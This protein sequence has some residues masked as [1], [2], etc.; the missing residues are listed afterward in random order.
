MSKHHI[1]KS[2]SEA[3]SIL[4]GK[5]RKVISGIRATTLEWYEEDK[6]A[7]YYH[8]TP[9]VIYC[10]NGDITLNSGG[11]KTVTTKARM[12]QALGNR[13]TVYQH[14]F[15]WYVHYPDNTA[16]TFIDNMSV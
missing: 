15:K 1:P 4:N 3:I 13:A 7:M 14:L 5:T 10:E 16:W 2:F 12:N 8:G 9:V 6:I 11:Y